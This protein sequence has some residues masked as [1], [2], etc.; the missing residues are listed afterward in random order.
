[1]EII[2]TQTP[3]PLAPPHHLD[4][5]A[6]RTLA[7]LLIGGHVVIMLA[8]PWARP[9]WAS[10][11]AVMA[12][13]MLLLSLYRGLAHHALRQ[14]AGAVVGIE[15]RSDGTV[16]LQSRHGGRRS[17]RI[18]DSST[19]HP[20]VVVLNLRDVTGAKGPSWPRHVIVPRDACEPEGFRRLRV[21]LRW[22]RAAA[23]EP[24]DDQEP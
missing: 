15:V 7:L 4:L 13:P 17:A 20:W 23:T 22:G 12:Y 6:S 16:V 5:G 19:V 10:W 14:A 1:M 21:W 9:E 2:R 8:L 18:L 11:L 24:T 3:V